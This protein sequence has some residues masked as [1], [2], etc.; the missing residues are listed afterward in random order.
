MSQEQMAGNVERYLERNA[1][2]TAASPDRAR[3]QE[4]AHEF[5]RTGWM[6]GSDGIGLLTEIIHRFAASERFAWEAE[7]REAV[8]AAAAKEREATSFARASQQRRPV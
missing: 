4:A 2:M 5:T 7:K 8:E 1:G 3:A 6:K